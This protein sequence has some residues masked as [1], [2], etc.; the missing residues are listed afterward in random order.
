RRHGSARLHE[1]TGKVPD[2]TPALYKLHWLN[3]HEP[4]LVARAHRVVDVH[5]YLVGRLTG[6]WCTSWASA[7]PLGLVDMKSLDYS[8]EVLAGVGV[9]RAQLPTL[10]AP[11]ETVGVLTPQV[12][13]SVGLRGDIPLIAG[14]GDG[15]CAGLGAD[16]TASGSAYLNLGT[17]VVSGMHS[18][19]YLWDRAFRTLASPLR[20]A[21]TLGAY[22]RA[23]DKKLS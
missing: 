4:G 10:V 11:G 5:G 8:D 18:S 2:P 9:Q 20:G 16:V 22:G 6:Q 14:A 7:D 12:A 1:L 13:E 17:A 21:Y 23:I 15:Q 3:E 19:Q